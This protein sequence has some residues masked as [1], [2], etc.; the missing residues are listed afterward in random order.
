MKEKEVYE[1]VV[2]HCNYC[3]V[4]GSTWRLH[5][6]HIE[7]R[8]EGGPTTLWNIIRLCEK[9]HIMVHSNKRVW[10]PR[11]KNI[12]AKIVIYECHYDR[13]FIDDILL[14]TNK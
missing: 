9:C 1:Y 13:K 12:L 5:N 4:C 2:E 3:A 7:Y 11:L 6:H 14:H 10:Q 8:S